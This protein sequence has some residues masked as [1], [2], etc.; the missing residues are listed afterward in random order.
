MV[1]R[2]F[3]AP[4]ATKGKKVTVGRKEKKEWM[5]WTV[6]MVRR[7]NKGR[8]GEMVIKGTKGGS[9]ETVPK[10]IKAWLG[11]MELKVIQGLKEIMEGMGQKVKREWKA[12]TG[13]MEFELKEIKVKRGRKETKE[14]VA[15]VG[16]HQVLDKLTIAEQLISSTRTV[17][18]I[19][20]IGY[21]E[22]KLFHVT[23]SV[24]NKIART[25]FK[26]Y[27]IIMLPS[28]MTVILSIVSKYLIMKLPTS[29]ICR[30]CLIISLI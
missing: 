5:G 2:E 12:L 10:A 23:T 29:L 19:H 7:V 1:E 4:K 30:I 18:Q 3:M 20:D 9:D 15:G 26:R 27:E 21:R 13:R 25:D 22:T 6:L 14:W 28:S 17:L 16:D 24:S 11:L 8:M